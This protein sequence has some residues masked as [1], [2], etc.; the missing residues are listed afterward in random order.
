VQGGDRA[1]AR[2]ASPLT[3]RVITGASFAALHT[4]GSRWR[5]TSR[6][7]NRLFQEAPK[8]AMVPLRFGVQKIMNGSRRRLLH[9]AAYAAVLP[10][11]SRF[12]FRP[13]IFQVFCVPQI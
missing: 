4:T 5:A 10:A 3:H 13:T 11:L 1:G 6:K 8:T 12:T 7:G 2:K 9:A